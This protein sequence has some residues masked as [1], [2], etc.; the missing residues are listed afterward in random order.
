VKLPVSL[1][2]VKY[3]D[4]A[5]YVW[6]D[7]GAQGGD[8]HELEIFRSRLPMDMFRKIYTDLDKAAVQYGRMEDHD[9]EEA[10]SRYLSSVSYSSY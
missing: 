10:R 4:I 2:N 8:I 9:N 5:P 7:P 1:S 6:L 3:L